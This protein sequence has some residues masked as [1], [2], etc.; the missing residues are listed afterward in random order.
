[1]SES[2]PFIVRLSLEGMKHSIETAIS[3]HLTSMDADIQRAID[4]ICTP[5]YV[6]KAIQEEAEKVI[7]Q[8]IKDQIAN[9]Y[10]YGDGAKVI[11]EVVNESLS[12][13]VKDL[14]K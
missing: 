14:R 12:F 3:Q 1:M 8:T 9:Y 4:E 2:G 6:A 5:Q 13:R 7:A 11:K 10:K